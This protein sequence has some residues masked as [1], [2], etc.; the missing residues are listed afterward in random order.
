MKDRQ[1][2]QEQI[3][4]IIKKTHRA[5]KS[6]RDNFKQGDFETTSSRAYYAVF[7]IMQGALL[8]KGLTYSKHSGVI[9]AFSKEFIKTGIFPKEFSKKIHRLYKNREISDY[10]YTLTIDNMQA[11]EDIDNATE[12]VSSIE[13]YIQAQIK[14]ERNDGP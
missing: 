6:A 14:E 11:Q 8:L 2:L 10:S 7:H 5:L 3:E 13:R 12:I 9:S 4:K 1:L